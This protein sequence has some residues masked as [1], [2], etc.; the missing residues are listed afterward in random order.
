M[1]KVKVESYYIR[2]L[3]VWGDFGQAKVIVSREKGVVKG[4]ARLSKE[5][6]VAK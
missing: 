4:K 1:K 2:G 5:I 6:E 3:V